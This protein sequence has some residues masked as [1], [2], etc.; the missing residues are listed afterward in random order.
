MVGSLAKFLRDGKSLD[1][2]GVADDNYPKKSWEIG[3]KIPDVI[4][5]DK[6]RE[7]LTIG[8]TKTA[9]D[10]INDHTRDSLLLRADREWRTEDLGEQIYPCTV[11]FREITKRKQ[12]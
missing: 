7:L 6:A 3:G 11:P 8:E 2:L 9:G 10:I 5:R 4:A 1:L 12:T